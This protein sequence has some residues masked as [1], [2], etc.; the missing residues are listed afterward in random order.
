MLEQTAKDYAAYFKLNISSELTS[1]QDVIDN[2]LT[3]LEE[4]TSVLQIVK[5][6]NSECSASVAEDII[7][8]RSEVTTLSKKINT[9]TDVMMRVHVNVDTL[10]KQVEKAELDFGVSNDNRIKSFLKPFL[11][12]VKEPTTSD[13]GTMPSNVPF[14]SVMNNFH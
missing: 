4:L 6:K 1:V 5:S 12:R 9:L 2:M 3:R 14:Q 13:V 10:E 7:K 11:M 8:Y